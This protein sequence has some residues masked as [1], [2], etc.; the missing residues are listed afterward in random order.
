MDLNVGNAMRVNHTIRCIETHREINR[1]KFSFTFE[2]KYLKNK[3]DKKEMN[4]FEF[5][6]IHNA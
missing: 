3:C 4:R 2:I 5:F 6:S 1:E